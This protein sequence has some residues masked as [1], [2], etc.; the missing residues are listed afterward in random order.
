MTW[1]RDAETVVPPGWA[2][3][4]EMSIVIFLILNQLLVDFGDAFV[5]D[6]SLRFH[7]I[8]PSCYSKSDALC[9]STTRSACRSWCRSNVVSRIRATVPLPQEAYQ[10]AAITTNPDFPWT[11]RGRVWFQ[12]AIVRASAAG[13]VAPGVT[14]VSFFGWT[15]GGI[16]C[17]EYDTNSYS[18]LRTHHFF[19]SVAQL[20]PPITFRYDSSPAGAYLEVVEMGAIVTTFGGGIGQWGSRLWVSTVQAEELCRAVWGVPAELRPIRFARRSVPN[21]RPKMRTDPPLYSLMK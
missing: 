12:P 9:L 8:K 4:V 15:L 3:G 11:F 21:H 2:G 20:P 10:P 1:T 7:K 19:S 14:T 13:T 16:V 5:F 6:L 18:L 17:L